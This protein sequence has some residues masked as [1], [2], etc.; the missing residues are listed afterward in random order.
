LRDP[1]D[2]DECLSLSGH[3]RPLSRLAS[4]MLERPAD[5]RRRI[6]LVPHQL[7]AAPTRRPFLIRPAGTGTRPD[8][9]AGFDK[10]K[11]PSLSERMFIS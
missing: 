7:G 8:I 10:P 6:A 2:L 1:D 11:M 4:F 9:T 3:Q 5:R